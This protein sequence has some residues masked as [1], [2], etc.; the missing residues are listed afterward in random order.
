MLGLGLVSVCHCF[1]ASGFRNLGLELLGFGPR[2][3]FFFAVVYVVSL[4]G[5]ASW[6]LFRKLRGTS[7]SPPSGSG[8]FAPLPFRAILL[9]VLLLLYYSITLL[10]Y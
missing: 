3:V 1:K 8:P 2:S 4:L 5:G 10:L 9:L 6:Q 7:S